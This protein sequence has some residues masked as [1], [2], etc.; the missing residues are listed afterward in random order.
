MPI[1]QG[2]AGAE[3]IED[4]LND[5]QT[6]PRLIGIIPKGLT[7]RVCTNGIGHPDRARR[8]RLPRLEVVRHF[9]RLLVAQ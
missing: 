7:E 8:P 2:R 9:R 4:L 6:D 5:R 1:C 3:V